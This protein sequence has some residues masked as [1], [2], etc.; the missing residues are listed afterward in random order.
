[1]Q[2]TTKTRSYGRTRQGGYQ[3]Q[4]FYQKNIMRISRRTVYYC[5]TEFPREHSKHYAWWIG[6]RGSYM[7]TVNEMWGSHDVVWLYQKNIMKPG[8]YD[9]RKRRG[10]ACPAVKP[11]TRHRH[12]GSTAS[13]CGFPVRSVDTFRSNVAPTATSATYPVGCDINLISCHHP[14]RRN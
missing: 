7:S 10:D 8:R 13:C 5:D 1:M 6:K 2:N 14:N 9:K 3:V 4:W 12:A 11:A